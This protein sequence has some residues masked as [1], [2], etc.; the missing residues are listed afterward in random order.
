VYPWLHHVTEAN[1]AEHRGE[2]HQ[3]EFRK[4]LACGVLARGFARLR[5]GDCGFERL[6][7]LNLNVHFHTLALD[8][9]FTATPDGALQ[10][11]PV[12]PPSDAEV[13]RLLATIRT[14]IQRLL[15]RRGLAAT[16]PRVP[17]L[18]RAHGAARDH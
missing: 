10:F 13:A 17:P 3:R 14:R 8:G 7:P 12:A 11:H 18:R 6:V 16:D 1:E 5:C 15:A 9:V 4:F 2:G